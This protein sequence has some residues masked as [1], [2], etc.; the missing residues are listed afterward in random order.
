MGMGYS[1]HYQY[2]S[3]VNSL[4]GRH[5]GALEKHLALCSP[6]GLHLLRP[7]TAVVHQ[8]ISRLGPAF[9]KHSSDQPSQSVAQPGRSDYFSRRRSPPS[10][11]VQ[12]RSNRPP[13]ATRSR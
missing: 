13:A 9:A 1:R 3:G 11:A 10:V 6:H 2:S 4:D 8:N 5:K 12:R 7:P